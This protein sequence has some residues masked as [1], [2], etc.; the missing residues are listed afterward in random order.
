[1]V[2]LSGF[3]DELFQRL[4]FRK[5]AFDEADGHGEMPGR[6]GDAF[7]SEFVRIASSIEAFAIK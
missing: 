6:N 3:S 5:R 4:I 7:A 2:G 1:M